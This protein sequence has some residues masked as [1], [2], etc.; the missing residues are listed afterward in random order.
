MG[1]TPANIARHEQHLAVIPAEH[2]IA[3]VEKTGADVDPHEGEVPL[4]AAAQPSSRGE[5]LG[6]VQQIFLRDLRAEA[7]EGAEYLKATRD[8]DQQ[9]HRIQPMR[10][11]HRPGMFVGGLLHFSGFGGL[12]FD[13]GFMHRS[14]LAQFYSP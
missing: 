7:G 14:F 6:P 1:Q 9:R 2:L 10:E 4:Q 3:E 12:D 13:Y 8:H 5:R 11:P